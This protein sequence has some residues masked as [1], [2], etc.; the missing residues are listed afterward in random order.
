[1]LESRS[2]SRA[3]NAH[4]ALAPLPVTYRVPGCVRGRESGP[5][6]CEECR[7]SNRIREGEPENLSPGYSIPLRSAAVRPDC[8]P[9]RGGAVGGMVLGGGL[10]TGGTLV[11]TNGLILMAEAFKGGGGSTGT[12][13]NF[14]PNPAHTPGQPGF[15]PGKTVE[16]GDSASVFEDAIQGKDG[17]WYGKGGNNEIYRYFSDNTGGAHFSGM[18]GEDGIPLDRVPIGVRRVFGMVR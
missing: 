14:Q 8:T 5:G 9:Y 3:P 7:R 2:R 12:K 13:P 10:I 15:N 6:V 11:G 4:A 16:P 18:T 1:V 17:N